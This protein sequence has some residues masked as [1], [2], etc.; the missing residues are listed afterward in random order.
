MIYQ[1]LENVQKLSVAENIF[2]G[3]LPDSNIPGFVN[4]KALLKHSKDVLNDFDIV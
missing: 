4:F 1:E 2:L 3:K